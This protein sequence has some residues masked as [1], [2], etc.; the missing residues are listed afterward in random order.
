MLAEARSTVQTRRRRPNFGEAA[1]AACSRYLRA[2]KAVDEADA[3]RHAVQLRRDATL[4]EDQAL[5]LA[6]AGAWEGLFV[7]ALEL[8]S[9][10][11]DPSDRAADYVRVMASLFTP[12]EGAWSPYTNADGTRSYTDGRGR[13]TAV[14]DAYGRVAPGPWFK[15]GDTLPDAP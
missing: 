13:V 6:C 7:A 3:H 2:A 10:I 9:T 15:D 11:P 4:T 5:E 12:L 14:M 1:S 8:D